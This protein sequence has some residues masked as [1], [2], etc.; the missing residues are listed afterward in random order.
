MT[1]QTTSPIQHRLTLS[2]LVLALFPVLSILLWFNYAAVL[3]YDQRRRLSTH[4]NRDHWKQ[5]IL[6]TGTDNSLG[7]NLARAFHRSG[8]RVIGADA[9]QGMLPS[10]AKLSRAV[11]KHYEL[12]QPSAVQH[13]AYIARSIFAIA[14]KENARLWIDCSNNIERMAIS[15]AKAE[16]E[17]NTSCT[18]VAFDSVRGN[19]LEDRASFFHLL[20]ENSLPSLEYHKVSSRGQIHNI[21]NHSQGQK[22]YLL[23]APKNAKPFNPRTLLP[24]RTISQ[25]YSEVARVK[26]AAESQMVLEESNDSSITYECLSIISNGSIKASWAKSLTSDNHTPLSESSALYK[27]MKSYTD[28]LLSALGSNFD[29]SLMLSFGLNEKITQAGVVQQILPLQCRLTLDSSWLLSFPYSVYSDLSSVY[30]NLLQ[31]NFNGAVQDSNGDEIQSLR[32]LSKLENEPSKQQYFLF[33]LVESHL[34]N[35]I[36][37]LL[38]RRTDVKQTLIALTTF[39]QRLMTWHETTYDFDDPI[40]AFSG[41]TLEF[42][43]RNILG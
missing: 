11:A 30:G 5:T 13:W 37:D 27:A 28:S 16:L 22:K 41:W 29:G 42:L 25:T 20:K 32:H 9:A 36:S 14:R 19:Q 23:T 7:L 10:P 4:H 3:L 43:W 38:Y 12:P 6:I 31:H 17:R 1:A 33:E 2:V 21:L 8:Y 35:P 40:P 34:L 15:D 39:L 18:C 26:F 24:R